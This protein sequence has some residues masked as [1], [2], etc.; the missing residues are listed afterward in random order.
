MAVAICCGLLYFGAKLVPA[1]VAKLLFDLTPESSFPFTIQNIM[2]V[3]F[4][5]GIGELCFRV[6]VNQRQRS[7]LGQNYLPDRPSDERRVLT[8]EDMPHI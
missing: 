8:V 6:F 1:P 4:S 7:A 5:V 2:W 3:M